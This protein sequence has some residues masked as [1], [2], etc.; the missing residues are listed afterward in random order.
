MTEYYKHTGPD[1][2]LLYLLTC[3]FPADITDRLTIRLTAEEYAAA[4][5]E[6]AEG[7]EPEPEPSDEISSG[8]F[9]E[10]LEAVL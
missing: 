7:A 1:G 5:A 2:E 6:L 8:E 10:M 4:L 9:M 3:D